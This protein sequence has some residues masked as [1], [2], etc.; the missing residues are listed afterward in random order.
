MINKE[1]EEQTAQGQEEE[2]EVLPETEN[3]SE[4]YWCLESLG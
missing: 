2:V 3:P 1:K 4:T